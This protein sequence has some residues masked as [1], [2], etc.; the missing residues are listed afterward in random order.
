VEYVLGAGVNVRIRSQKINF[1]LLSPPAASDVVTGVVLIFTPISSYI[2]AHLNERICMTDKK[3]LLIVDDDESL[4]VVLA[5]ALTRSN[6]EVATAA[7][8]LLA[9]DQL[10]KQ[11]FD[12]VLLD[13]RM[14]NMDGMEV[15]KNIREEDLAEK[16]IMLTGVAELKFA[17]ESLMSGAHDFMSKPVDLDAL[18]NCINRVLS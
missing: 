10:R 12:L 14:P 16:V 1:S 8:G 13:I 18:Q 4:R 2:V 17:Q 15:L 5:D 11:R 9:M 3:R 7:D 6:F